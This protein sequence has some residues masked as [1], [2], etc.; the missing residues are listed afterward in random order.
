[1]SLSSLTLVTAKRIRATNQ[2]GYKK[3]T[4]YCPS[5]LQEKRR[6]KYALTHHEQLVLYLH[7]TDITEENSQLHERNH[8][9]SALPAFS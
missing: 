7:V 1:M 5:E 3:P 9:P 2:S 6:F 8:C 4:N